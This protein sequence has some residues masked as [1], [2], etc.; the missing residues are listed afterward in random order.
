MQWGDEWEDGGYDLRWLYIAACT[1][2]LHR[3][4]LNPFDPSP[5]VPGAGPCGIKGGVFSPSS[6]LQKFLEFFHK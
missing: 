3:F 5:S 1:V 4:W 2:C 6:L